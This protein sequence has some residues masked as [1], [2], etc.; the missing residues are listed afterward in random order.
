M[1]AES[2]HRPSRPRR[3]RRPGPRP[4][5]RRLARF[6]LGAA[7][8]IAGVLVP[9]EAP[10]LP[11]SP[12]QAQDPPGDGLETPGDETPGDPPGDGTPDPGTPDPGT[13]D[14]GGGPFAAGTPENCPPLYQPGGVNGALCLLELSACRASPP[15]LGGQMLEPSVDLPE[16]PDADMPLIGRYPD[17]CEARYLEKDDPTAYEACTDPENTRGFYVRVHVMERLFDEEGNPAMVP[18]LDDNGSPVTGLIRD[19][20]G[21]WTYGP[22]M[23][24]DTLDLCRIIHPTNCA[25]GS[26]TGPYQCRAVRRRTWSCPSGYLPRNDFNTCF[27]PLSLAPGEQHPACG[28]GRPTLVALDCA[29][30]A[31]DDYAPSPRDPAWACAGDRFET[32]SEDIRLQPNPENRYWC[33]FDA[34][35]LRVECHRAS[36]PAGGCTSTT[37]MCLKRASRTGGCNAIAD[38]IRCR[39]LQAALADGTGTSVDDIREAG[40]QPCVLLAFEPRPSD[41]P[42]DV[43]GQPAAPTSSSQRYNTI[44]TVKADFRESIYVGGRNICRNV[45]LGENVAE[46][47]AESAARG[48]CQDPPAGNLTW[49]STHISQFAVVNLPVIL[50]VGDVPSETVEIGWFSD[51]SRGIFRSSRDYLTYPDEADPAQAQAHSVIRRFPALDPAVTVTNLESF[52]ANDQGVVCYYQDQPVF[53]VVVEELSPDGDEAV[54][55]ELFGAGSLDWWDDLTV[56]ERDNLKAARGATRT[57]EVSCN[58]GD[59]IWC[60]WTPTRSGY[61]RLTAAGAWLVRGLTKRVRDAVRPGPLQAYSLTTD[62]ILNDPDA[63]RRLMREEGLQPENLG[64]NEDLNGYLPLPMVVDQDTGYTLAGLSCRDLRITCQLGGGGSNHYTE[65]DPIGIVVHEVRVATRTPNS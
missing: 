63:I 12:V 64:L 48:V 32:G 41:C 18:V 39:S 42:A 6:L 11:D 15:A 47:V 25:A 51:R 23:E 36:P 27:R 5:R 30:Y 34:S 38:T 21:Y 54:I 45:V 50:T 22:L 61:Y 55:E 53:R 31:G 44:H 58:R 60:R 52:V 62:P 10:A 57:I 20:E 24:R 65:S 46:C 26:Q 17:F 28:D 29:D 13:P 8:V 56:E 2:A 40:C 35:D 43:G 33:R 1:I 16:I 14:S 4:R 37:A 9:L 59:V 19:S 3:A 49:S 7:L